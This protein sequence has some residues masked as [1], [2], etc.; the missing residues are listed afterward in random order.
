M[1]LLDTS[2]ASEV[3]RRQPDA[4]RRLRDEDPSGVWLCTP[5][6]A[7]IQFGLSRLPDGSLRRR[8]IES[9]F[10]RLRAAVRW[11]DWSESASL[12]F[13]RWKS[14]L[15]QRGSP[16][17]DMDLAIASIAMTLPARLA[18]LNTRHFCRI[19]TLQVD[20]WSVATGA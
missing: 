10:R 3:M 19:D 7:E 1:L 2:A 20:D 8:L 14:L 5:V 16:I 9:E 13:G 17:E 6:A 15:Q 4:L 11:T 12:A 18:T